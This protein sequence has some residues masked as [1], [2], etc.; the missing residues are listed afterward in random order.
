MAPA[1]MEQPV[2]RQRAPN[3]G[4]SPSPR[5][6]IRLTVSLHCDRAG[7]DLKEDRCSGVDPNRPPLP[8]KGTS[9]GAS[10]LRLGTLLVDLERRDTVSRPSM[11]WPASCLP[12]RR[13]SPLIDKPRYR[14]AGGAV[15]RPVEA[16]RRIRLLGGRLGAVRQRRA[17]RRRDIPPPRRRACAAHHRV[18][19]QPSGILWKS[20]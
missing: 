9:R 13:W 19:E 3:N 16:M 8:R 11:S 2:E 17:Y 14:R 15:W 12:T 1:E 6:G 10:P 5:G 20:L 18:V 7:A 4:V